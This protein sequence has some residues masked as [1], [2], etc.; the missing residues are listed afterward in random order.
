V[1]YLKLSSVK[2]SDV[3]HYVEAAAGTK[4]FVIDIRNYPSDNV[5]FTLGALLVD[6]ESPFVRFTE[7]ELSTPGAFR[8]TSP[9]S[10]APKAP[11]YTGK[12]AILIDEISQSSAEYTAM[13]FR[14]ARTAV[15]VGSTTAGAD[16]NMSDFSLPGGQRSGISGI[17][18]FYP[19]KTPTQR[20][21]IVPDIEARPTVAGVLSGRD[22]VLETALRYI[23]GNAVSDQEVQKMAH[24]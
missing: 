22:E 6:Q 9:V 14:S 21:G 2:S 18:V 10:L 17:G 12:V 4:G 24:R 3:A 7:P 5:M 8:W 16:G 15:V 11:H 1:A 13:A 20:V 19:D 23:L